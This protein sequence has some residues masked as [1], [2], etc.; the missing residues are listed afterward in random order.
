MDG[1]RVFCH[2]R[3]QPRLPDATD[4]K[5][6]LAAFLVF[7]GNREDD[8]EGIADAVRLRRN[9]KVIALSR[10][11]SGLR[12]WGRDEADDPGELGRRRH[13]RVGRIREADGQWLLVS[14]LALRVPQ[15]GGRPE[16]TYTS[17][18]KSRGRIL[19]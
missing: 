12:F 17:H 18:S 1:I 6:T 4:L 10:S 7:R 9:A 5:I 2:D 13:L 19:E 3:K 14:H 8:V 16:S 11:N 15:V